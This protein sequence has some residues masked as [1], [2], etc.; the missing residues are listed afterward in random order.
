MKSSGWSAGLTY[1]GAVVGAG[2]ASGQEIY[3]FFTRFGVLGVYGIGFAGFMFAVLGYL[4]FER[5]RRM[6]VSSYREL[7]GSL[8]PPGM[9]RA[10][11]TMISA[12]LFVGLGI[13]SSAGGA[14]VAQLTGLPMVLGGVITTL[15]VVAVAAKGIRGVI[16]LNTLLIP[17]L[18]VMIL[19]IAVL[20][21]SAPALVEASAPRQGW[22]V[23]AGLYFSYNI[24]TAI[25]MLVGVGRTLT[26]FRQS[27]WGALLGA[28]LLSLLAL[29][30]HHLLMTLPRI[31]TLPL[32]DAAWGIHPVWGFLFGIGLWVALFT[33]G[34][35]EAY[36]LTEQY[37]KKVLWWVTATFLLGLIRF[38]DL[39]ALLYPVMGMV[40]MVLWIPL[41]YKKPGRGLPGG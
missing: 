39:V 6:Q 34:I 1:V 24:F 32:V 10:T 15:G 3:Q 7:L 14:D 5:G 8:Y 9:V 2:F 36:V 33:T 38:D 40:A 11:E 13:V 27:L 37:G 4:A 35:A 21:W 31:G 19:T 17:Y 29:A 26:S 16:R 18:V 22:L 23:A 25:M 41:V 12:F 20:N 30:E 28:G